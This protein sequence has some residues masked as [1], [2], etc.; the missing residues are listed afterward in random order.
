LTNR[1]K[2]KHSGIPRLFY[3]GL[4]FTFPG[5]YRVHRTKG[6][7]DLGQEQKLEPLRSFSTLY[8]LHFPL[9]GISR[10][11]EQSSSRMALDFQ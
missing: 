3:S 2:E 11:V 1:E 7:R 9:P 4:T 6:T 8:A 10:A 5:V